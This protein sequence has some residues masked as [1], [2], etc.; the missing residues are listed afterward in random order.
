MVTINCTCMSLSLSPS[1]PL[2]LSLPLSPS[3][4]PS[5]SPLLPPSLSHMYRSKGKGCVYYSIMYMYM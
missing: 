1:L 4:S 5:L 3:P 2:P